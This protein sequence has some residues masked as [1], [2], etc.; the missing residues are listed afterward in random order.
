MPNVAPGTGVAPIPST[1]PGVA[2]GADRSPTAQPGSAVLTAL[3]RIAEQVVPRPAA[4]AAAA[5]AAEFLSRRSDEVA[6]LA[7]VLDD[8]GQP[9]AGTA[10]GTVMAVPE[11]GT[12]AVV[13]LALAALVAQRWRRRTGG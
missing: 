4:A 9:G 2:R 5:A 8:K 7:Q 6:R 13:L 12:L 3:G 11:P 10:Q 1:G